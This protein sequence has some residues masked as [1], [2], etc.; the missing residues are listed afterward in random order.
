MDVSRKR[1]RNMS[2]NNSSRIMSGRDAV[3]IGRS[4]SI[5]EGNRLDRCGSVEGKVPRLGNSSASADPDR[6]GDFISNLC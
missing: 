4:R 3:L 2:T 5:C 1:A 6:K